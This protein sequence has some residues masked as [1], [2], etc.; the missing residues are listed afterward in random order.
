M[1]LL[2]DSVFTPLTYSDFMAPVKDYMEVYND[3]EA[4]YEDLVQN[5]F[6]WEDEVKQ[7]GKNNEKAR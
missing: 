4:K 7:G 2:I 1:N 5:T 6:T 3:R